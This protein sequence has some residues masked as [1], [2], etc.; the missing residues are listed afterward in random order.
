MKQLKVDYIV[1]GSGLAGVLFSDVL[2]KNN[3]SFIVIDDESQKSSLV[4]GGLYNPVILKRFT[5]VWKA[6]EQLEI[7]L[8]I[9]K[10]LENYLGKTI[11][12][13]LPVFRLFS[14]I[15]EQNNWFSACDKINL[16]EYMET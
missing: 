8:P 16:T 5:P 14:S 2:R 9:Y 4:A 11:D 12:Y 6:K 15:E 1:V 7:A 10:E 3:K 13:K